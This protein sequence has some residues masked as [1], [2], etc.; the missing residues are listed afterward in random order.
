MKSQ[1]EVLKVPTVKDAGPKKVTTNVYTPGVDFIVPVP[2]NQN[3]VGK[4]DDGAGE[5]NQIDI[6]LC[7]VAR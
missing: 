6:V 2:P 5:N 1:V 7:Q 3:A 4:T